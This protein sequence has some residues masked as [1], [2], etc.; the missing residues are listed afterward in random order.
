MLYNHLSEIETSLHMTKKQR[1]TTI[2][3]KIGSS[4][5]S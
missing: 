1:N 2:K 4:L 5:K 3:I